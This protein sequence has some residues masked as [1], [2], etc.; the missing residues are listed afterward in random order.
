[1]VHDFNP[2]T[3]S[4]GRQLSEFKAS[5][6]YIES[7]RTTR[8]VIQKNLV[9]KKKEESKNKTH[10]PTNK[11]ITTTKEM[12]IGSYLKARVLCSLYHSEF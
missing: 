4:K 10:E 11:A 5:L 1:M 6:V 12:I 7:S 9:W 2:S 8:A 3:A